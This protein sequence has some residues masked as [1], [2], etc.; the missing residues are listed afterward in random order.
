MWNQA[1]L[2]KPTAVD[3]WEESDSYV[4]LSW[5]ILAQWMTDENKAEW[6]NEH[7]LLTLS[8][9]WTRNIWWNLKNFLIVP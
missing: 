5:L 8:D 4:P 9:F 6:K 3:G 1:V 2:E 7:H